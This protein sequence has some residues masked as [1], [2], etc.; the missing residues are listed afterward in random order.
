MWDLKPSALV[1]AD[2]ASKQSSTSQGLEICASENKMHWTTLEHYIM[3]VKLGTLLIGHVTGTCVWVMC[4]KCMLEW[5]EI[6]G[7]IISSPP[8]AAPNSHTNV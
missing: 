7:V 2:K 8:Q 3:M 1:N 6:Y 5:S 4:K